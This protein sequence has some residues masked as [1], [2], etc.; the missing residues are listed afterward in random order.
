ML[1]LLPPSEGKAAS[2]RGAP[3]KP[4]SLSLPG[5]AGARAAVLD[6]LVELCAADEDKAR[7]VLGLSEGLRGEIAKNVELR[8][9]GTRPAGQIYTGVL[10]DALDLATL[11]PDARRRARQSL[12][13]FSGLWGA[14]R[15]TDRIPSYRCS[16]GVKLPGLGALGAHWREPMASVLPEAAGDGLVLD[17]RSSAYAAAWKP[18]GEVAGRTATV[19]VLHAPTRKVVSHFNKATKG[20]LVRDLLT[21]GAKPTGPAELVEV[22]RDLG[23][24]VESEA[25]AQ[26]GRPWALD[27]LVTQIH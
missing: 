4:E 9:A 12:L 14:V 5:L 15:I 11:E 16:M 24:V 3:L 18:K 13:V 7:E 26:A 1:V 23:Y 2:G 6:E 8:T 21:A 22:L 17:L 10:Y 25:P 19:R 20:R 27:V